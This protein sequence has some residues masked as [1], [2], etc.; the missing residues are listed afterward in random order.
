MTG[1]H[2]VCNLSGFDGDLAV[3]KYV[4]LLPEIFQRF[5]GQSPTYWRL[6]RPVSYGLLLQ[7]PEPLLQHLKQKHW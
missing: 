6:I 1:N 5:Q 3:L 4:R 2:H 7:V